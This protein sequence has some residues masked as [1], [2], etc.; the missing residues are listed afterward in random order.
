MSKALMAFPGAGSNNDGMQLR[1][2]FAAKAIEAIVNGAISVG[3]GFNSYEESERLA[4]V[5]Y[6]IADA[7]MAGRDSSS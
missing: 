1:D 6:R 7:M 4:E 3:Q 5:A 2:F